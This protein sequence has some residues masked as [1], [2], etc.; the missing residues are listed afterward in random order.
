MGRR[1]ADAGRQNVGLPLTLP[2]ICDLHQYQ[3]SFLYLTFKL[4][5]YV[6]F[7]QY[8][9]ARILRLLYPKIKTV[10]IKVMDGLKYFKS[11]QSF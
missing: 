4:T 7:L 5:V 9:L 10:R 8:N 6:F 2:I 1:N 11:F 3:I